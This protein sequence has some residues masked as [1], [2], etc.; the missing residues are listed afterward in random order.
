MLGR[1]IYIIEFYSTIEHTMKVRLLLFFGFFISGFHLQ[2]QVTGSDTVCAGSIYNYSVTIPGAVTYTWTVPANWYAMTGQG[3]SQINVNCNTN[4]GQVCAEGFD[5]IGNSLGTEC[6]TTTMGIEGG[7]GGGWSLWPTGVGSVCNFNSTTSLTPTITFNPGGGNCP[8]GCGS[9]ISNPNI[10]FAIYSGQT[11][12]GVIGTQMTIGVGNYYA[13]CVDTSLGSN[14][15]QAVQI[16]GGCGGSG[17]GSFVINFIGLWPWVGQTPIPVCVGDTVVLDGSY[18]NVGTSWGPYWNISSGLI[19]I[20]N[21]NDGSQMTAIVTSTNASVDHSMV[22]E[23]TNGFNWDFCSASTNFNVNAIYCNTTTS[24]QSSVSNI[25]ANSCINFTNF[26]QHATNY[27]WSF[28]GGIPSTSTDTNPSN[29][30][31]NIP[32]AYDVMLISSNPDY[33]D[34]LLMPGYITVSSLPLSSF[35]TDLNNVCAPACIDFTSTSQ[36]ATSYTWYFPGASTPTSTDSFPQN[37]CY[38]SAGNFGIVLISSNAA[39]S[40]TLDVSNYI[41]IL[42]SPQSSMTAT[43]L[44]ICPGSCTDISNTSSNATSYSWTFQGATIDSSSL[45]DPTNICYNTPGN[46]DVILVSVNGN[47]TDTLF[48]SGYITVYSQPPPPTIIQSGDSLIANTGY[49]TYQWYYSGNVIPGATENYYVATQNGDYN[50]IIT[51][52]NACE[53]EA[54]INNVIANQLAVGSGQWAIFPNPVISILELRNLKQHQEIS[55]NIYNIIGTA[56]S[57]H[58]AHCSLPTCSLDVSHLLPGPYILV[59]S[60]AGKISRSRFIKN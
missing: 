21:L 45:S 52:S 19:P 22:Y 13:A 14:F 53:V 29:I 31:Y 35:T 36:N 8:A 60:D 15:P 1:E 18:G 4:A 38:A 7:G 40:D 55:I 42:Q 59:I 9:G 49:T 5:S 23:I 48:A 3:T 6:L 16:S 39:C 37:I 28:P 57:L 46:F 43:D 27:Q 24:F 56:V 33:T 26:S 20:S 12:I 51:D 17:G 32:G 2:A 58:T 41:S 34:T 11:F 10:V 54:A 30:C 50:L 25:C 47:C 44:D